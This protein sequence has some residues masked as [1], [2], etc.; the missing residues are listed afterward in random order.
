[1]PG[2]IPRLSTRNYILNALPDEDYD[3]LRPD[4]EEMD[5]PRGKNIYRPDEPIK[6]VYF[7]DSSMISVVTN[8]SS[9][10]SIEAGIIGW[11]GMAG[12]EVLMGVDST[13]NNE[14]M[15]QLA[16]G[17]ARIKTELIRKEFERGGALHKLALRYMHALLMQVSQTA[18]CNRLHSLEQRLSRWLLM[19][20]DRAGADEIRLTQEFLSIML[21]VNRPT[22]SIAAT[23]LQSA[24]YIKYSRG[25]ITIV[26]GPMLEKFTCEC[27]SAVKKLWPPAVK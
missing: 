11:E 9:G 20:R 24:G 1:M 8:T 19:C 18:L 26:D 13:P 12:I 17:A 15:V 7:P 4:L 3:R 27:Y 10:E 14:S 6:Y 22:V 5:L 23:T 25:R 16:D 21:G 2:K